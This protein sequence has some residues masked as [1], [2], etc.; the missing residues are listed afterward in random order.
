MDFRAHQ[1]VLVHQ[2]K[3]LTGTQAHNLE[4]SWTETVRYEHTA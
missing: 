4:V 1:Q 2:R 3:I